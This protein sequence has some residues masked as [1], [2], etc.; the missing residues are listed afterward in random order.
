MRSCRLWL[1]LSSC[2]IW[3]KLCI[4]E[5][6]SFASNVLVLIILSDLLYDPFFGRFGVWLCM[7]NLYDV[8]LTNAYIYVVSI[9][10][11]VVFVYLVNVAMVFSIVLLLMLL[12]LV[13]GFWFPSMYA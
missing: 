11:C 13:N 1:L 4:S 8:Y 7:C 2:N 3:F 6:I 5:C 10:R 9:R 12:T